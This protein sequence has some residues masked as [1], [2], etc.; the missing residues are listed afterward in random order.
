MTNQII[1]KRK[2]KRNYF[3]LL[4]IGVWLLSICLISLL[5][6]FPDTLKEAN[7]EVE[8]LRVLIGITVFVLLFFFVYLQYSRE[9]YIKIELEG[10]IVENEEVE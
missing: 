4:V 2:Y 6:N 7:K 8:G 5:G 10:K 3:G 9:N 1:I